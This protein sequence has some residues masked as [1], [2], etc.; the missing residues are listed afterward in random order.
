MYLW[1]RRHR[2][3]GKTDGSSKLDYNDR[4]NR[5]EDME[6]PIF[7]WM[8]IANATENFSDKNKLGEGGF[9]PVYKRGKKLRLKDFQ[10]V[11]DKEWRNSKMKSF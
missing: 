6:L 10:K 9:G 2:K 7:D 11:P 8:A 5:K 3:Q 1:K 4:G